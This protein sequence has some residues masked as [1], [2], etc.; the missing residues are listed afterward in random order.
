MSNLK[1]M[2]LEIDQL[3]NKAKESK[4]AKQSDD[5]FAHQKSAQSQ[6]TPTDM[7]INAMEKIKRF[8]ASEKDHY[9]I[10]MGP[11]GSG[12]T[13]VIAHAI[14]NSINTSADTVNTSNSI[15]IAF[16]AFTNK[17]TQVLK[18][19]IIKLALGINSSFYTI[20]RL[21][22]L[23]PNLFDEEG[24][25]FK[26]NIKKIL[27][28]KDYNI[29]IF[30]E[31][32]TISKELFGYIVDSIN[33][34]KKVY[35]KTIKLIFI[36]DYW[37]LSPVGEV[38]SII[39]EQAI[40]DKWQVSKLAKVMRSA[41]D[42]ISKVNTHLISC[43]D[44]FRNYKENAEFIDNFV[45]GYPNNLISKEFFITIGRLYFMF[46]DTWLKNKIN[47]CVILTYTRKNCEKINY[48]IED[49]LDQHYNRESVL[50]RTSDYY[51]HSG[52]RCCLDRPIEAK[53]ITLV[54]NKQ[55]VSEVKQYYTIEDA[56]L[57]IRDV[58]NKEVIRIMNEYVTEINSGE[59]PDEI[60]KDTSFSESTTVEST[61][62]SIRDKFKITKSIMGENDF[63]FNGEIFDIVSVEDSHC[64]T[65]L[66]GWNDDKE[67]FTCQIL[68]IKK[69]SSDKTHKIIHIPE[70]QITK[71]KKQLRTLLPNLVY[72]TIVR[73]FNQV[74]P[75]L[76]YGYSITIY[77]SQGS[78]W[79]TVFI[80]LNSIKYSI[81]NSSNQ[82]ITLEQ[83]K[84][85]FKSTYTAISRAKS[86]LYVAGF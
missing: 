32:S 48:A 44:K 10:L 50:E 80:N 71:K 4:E 72:L 11:A 25:S 54:E 63:L 5:S 49:I 67:L 22:Q 9:F 24:L 85:L 51:F 16:C 29:I 21:L 39:F 86:N 14:Y 34:I 28:L 64:F 12:K 68:T 76:S 30:D 18:N 69:I 15:N 61:F 81:V 56:T 3:L 58:N 65:C 66:N 82:N 57:H 74:Y 6:F 59:L 38:I 35:D 8:I 70:M 78:E 42:K 55:Y 17:A 79:D 41:N 37:Q 36:G 60:A 7:Q 33:H 47:S 13:T 45:A 52:D 40:K 53:A 73:F 19:S 1:E 84:T 75:K 20:H 27:A 77:K 62:S 83:K 2:T 43:I 26:F 46:I 31:C 23:E